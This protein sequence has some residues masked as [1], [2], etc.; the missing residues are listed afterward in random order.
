[1]ACP[2][3]ARDA[4]ALTKDPPYPQCESCERTYTV[5]QRIWLD[6]SPNKGLPDGTTY[7][8]EGQRLPDGSMSRFNI[9]GH[10][11]NITTH[12]KTKVTKDRT[13]RGGRRFR[14]I[15]EWLDRGLTSRATLYTRH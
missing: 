5:G 13:W 4:F 3:C 11:V 15:V 6:S 7:L 9:Y 10:P 8:S 14:V 2:V 12:P 1:M